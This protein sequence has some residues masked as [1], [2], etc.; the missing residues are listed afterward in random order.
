LINK[1]TSKRLV[2]PLLVPIDGN[3][4]GHLIDAL[5]VG[6]QKINV[7]CRTI[8]KGHWKAITQHFGTIEAIASFEMIEYLCPFI[9]RES[10][11]V[12]RTF[13]LNFEIA[14]QLQL[15]F[16]LNFW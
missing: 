11:N 16:D 4:I 10:R 15:V 14:Q 7:A 8:I 6:K 2:W 9:C 1:V 3:L 5:R 13:N 12:I